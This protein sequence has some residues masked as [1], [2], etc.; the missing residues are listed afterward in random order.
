MKIQVIFLTIFINLNIVSSSNKNIFLFNKNDFCTNLNI[1]NLGCSVSS[2]DSYT[3]PGGKIECL[4]RYD[5]YEFD[6]DFEYLIG[7][8]NQLDKCCWS[9]LSFE[10]V[11]KIIYQS[12][13]LINFSKFNVNGIY[14]S[15]K[16]VYK[17]D[18]NA[19]DMSLMSDDD[20]D[21][22]RANFYIELNTLALFEDKKPVS[23]QLKDD[24]FQNLYCK[25][26][27]FTNFQNFYSKQSLVLSSKMFIYSIIEQLVI[28]KSNFTG[29]ID[30]YKLHQQE[31]G[32]LTTLMIVDSSFFKGKINKFSIGYFN[33]LENVYIVNSSIEFIEANTFENEIKQLVLDNNLLVKLNKEIFKHLSKLEYL[34]LENN[35]LVIIEKDTFEIFSQNLKKLCLKSTKIFKFENFY[36]LMPAIEELVLSSNSFI[37]TSDLML[38]MK[39]SP[40]LKYLDV[41]NIMNLT[42]ILDTLEQID[43]LVSKTT[44]LKYFDIRNEGIIDEKEFFNR[45]SETYLNSLLSKTFIHVNSNHPCNCAIFYLYKKFLTYEIPVE[46]S[47]KLLENTTIFMHSYVGVRENL[48]NAMVLLPKCYR[49]LIFNKPNDIF[50]EYSNNCIIKST[51]KRMTE[52]TS[53]TTVLTTTETKTVEDREKITNDK[54][55]D[56]HYALPFMILTFVC[57]F[58]AVIIIA[59]KHRVEHRSK[60]LKSCEAVTKTIEGN[61][62]NNNNNNIS[63]LSIQQSAYAY[64]EGMLTDSIWGSFKFQKRKKAW[65]LRFK[66]L[67]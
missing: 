14:L 17:I 11:Y 7:T 59:V 23:L 16:N 62:N 35:P 46:I 25:Q 1:Q 66:R 44:D 5:Q 53:S 28:K 54:T 64:P 56:L 21:Y 33:G 38:I 49:N 37:T 12:L 51:T 15:F 10:N 4:F 9:S 27:K 47:K 2:E 52:A 26:L 50:D 39:K 19:F 42:N 43:S 36:P 18:S 60:F 6:N 57:M 22:F 3:C 67:F 29:F 20:I 61:E 24:T 34:S 32:Y 55:I 8:L 58:L 48:E 30:D 63:T 31:L 65:R 45:V 40:K 41:S 13:L